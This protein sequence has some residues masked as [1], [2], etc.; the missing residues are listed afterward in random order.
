MIKQKKIVEVLMVL[1]VIAF[2]V[3]GG[4]YL[5]KYQKDNNQTNNTVDVKTTNY[6]VLENYKVRIPY[7]DELDN[8]KL[9]TESVS[10]YD[11]NDK[12]I[13]ILAPELDADWTCEPDPATKN[14]GTIGSIS[15]TKQEKRAGEYEP[16]ATKKIGEYTFGF[17]P[18]GGGCTDNPKYPELIDAFAKQF[19][20][21]ESF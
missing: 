17:E 8:F 1:I 10:S 13:E 15:I 14:K 11:V 7:S 12:F 21:L 20:N 4:I 6:L 2:L 16:I 19:E 5:S 18:S 9:G 3:V